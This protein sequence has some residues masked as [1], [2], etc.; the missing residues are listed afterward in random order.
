[1][2]EQPQT[3]KDTPQFKMVLLGDAG[4]G[5]TTWVRRLKRPED[6]PEPG[7]ITTAIVDTT[8]LILHTSRGDIMLNIWDTGTI[9]DIF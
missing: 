3:S 9:I 8:Y 1:M 2:E 6:Q 4:V 5:K 7:Y